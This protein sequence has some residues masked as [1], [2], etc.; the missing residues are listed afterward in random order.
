MTAFL[1]LAALFFGEVFEQV[2]FLPNW[3]IG[4]VAKNVRHF[5]EFK[6]AVDPGFFFFSGRARHGD[7]PSCSAEIPCCGRP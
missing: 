3:L 5:R 6:H 2:V 7:G 4:D 1:S